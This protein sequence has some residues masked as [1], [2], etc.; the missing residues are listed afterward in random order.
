MFIRTPIPAFEN[1]FSSN[2]ENKIFEDIEDENFIK[3]TNIST[4]KTSSV[5]SD[6]FYDFEVS[7]RVN[8]NNSILQEVKDINVFVS[9]EQIKDLLKRK[10]LL[11]GVDITNNDAINLATLYGESTRAHETV[12]LFQK[13]DLKKVTSFDVKNLYDENIAKKLRNQLISKEQAFGS[14]KRFVYKERRKSKNKTTNRAVKNSTNQNYLKINQGN[15]EESVG[16][17]NKIHA[18]LE[19]QKIA[20]NFKIENIV[21]AIE[22]SNSQNTLEH[23]K[24][25]VSKTS[26]K[27][28]TQLD[29]AINSQLNNAAN[30]FISAQFEPELK[31]E[32][33]ENTIERIKKNITL[34]S[35]V[36]FKSKVTFVCIAYDKNNNP[37]DA[38]EK[39]INLSDLIADLNIPDFNFDMQAVRVSKQKI[40]VRINNNENQGRFFNVY[41]QKVGKYRP[42]K[43]R[44]FVKVVASVYIP[45]KNYAILLRNKTFSENANYNFRCNIVNNRKEYANA[46]FSSVLTKSYRPDY[47]FAGITAFPINGGIKVVVK[48]LP[49]YASSYKIIRRN[50]T[51]KEKKYSPVNIVTPSSFSPMHYI[52]IAKGSIE[53]IDFTDTDVTFNSYEYKIMILD[54]NGQKRISGSSSVAKYQKKSDIVSISGTLNQL[55]NSFSKKYKL[56]VNIVKKENDADSLFLS[57]FGNYYSLFEEEL[58]KIKDVNLLT[59]SLDVFALNMDTSDVINLGK[60]GVSPDG[61]ASI[62]F[63]LPAGF[64]YMIQVSPRVLPPTEALSKI[65]DR[66]KYLASAD[67]DKPVSRYS[68][69]ASKENKKDRSGKVASRSASKFSDFHFR[70]FGRISSPSRIVIDENYDIFSSATT[71]DIYYQ[72]IIESDSSFATLPPFI[73]EANVQEINKNKNNKN[74]KNR[75]DFGSSMFFDASFSLKDPSNAIDYIVMFYRENGMPV[76]KYGVANCVVSE[77]SNKFHYIFELTGCIGKITFIAQP[78]LKNGKFAS[79]SI[80]GVKRILK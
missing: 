16:S 38:F 35:D 79:P 64:D 54:E 29:A 75:N 44:K 60:H 10:N 32:I 45:A 58:K 27:R 53:D 25:V 68:Y 2:N 69:A 36:V 20:G 1:N 13:Y 26:K 8:K 30:T 77:Y 11:D 5:G 48:N 52:K 46:K 6:K 41:C 78:V 7:I 51:K 42:Y 24:G 50:L 37:V 23:I 3:L 39:E 61:N 65:Q 66:I 74:N 14:V 43:L 59:Y 62:D 55:N 76:T 47:F 63:K 22:F 19:K 9:P 21:N 15:L 73:S 40:I 31:L 28:T 34:K 67:F 71:G 56:N 17:I 72:K 4:K 70:N 12:D 33:V 18:K 80:L 57:L 49:S